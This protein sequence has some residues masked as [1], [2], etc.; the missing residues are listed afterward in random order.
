MPPRKKKRPMSTILFIRDVP[1]EVM[2]ALD[3]ELAKRKAGD[4]LHRH[5]SRTTL[6]LKFIR[7]GL[8]RLVGTDTTATPTE[9]P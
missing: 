8:A 3:E 7:D 9:T 5:L 6:A 1:R 4:E 2:E